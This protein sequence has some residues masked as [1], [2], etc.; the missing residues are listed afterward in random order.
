[1]EILNNTKKIAFVLKKK[2][3][4]HL[5]LRRSRRT[6]EHAQIFKRVDRKR[7]LA[8]TNTAR[9]FVHVCTSPET[10]TSSGNDDNR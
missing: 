4:K 1:M 6:D 10:S 5:N 8:R 2:K 3:C 9:P 7:S